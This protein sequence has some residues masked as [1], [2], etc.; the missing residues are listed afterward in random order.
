VKIS[1]EHGETSPLTY[2]HP[3]VG[4]FPTEPMGLVHPRN[5]PKNSLKG[6]WDHRPFL[7]ETP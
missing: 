3:R 2:D 6:P 4:G 1:L 7:M 5:H